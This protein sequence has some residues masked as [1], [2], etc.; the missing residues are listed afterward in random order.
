[1]TSVLIVDDHLLVRQGLKLMLSQEFRDLVFGEAKNNDEAALRL[2]KRS[3]DLVIL[4][5]ALPGKDGFYAL[6]EIRRRH[7]SMRVLVLSMHA[8]P[9]YAMRARQMGAS[10]YVSKNA[11]RAELLRAFKSV[12]AG[13]KYFENLPS[14]GT[15]VKTAPER[16]GL[17]TREHA[18]ML[19]LAAG[20]SPGEIAAELNLSVK[21]ISTYKCR[22]LDKLALH[23]TAGLVRYVIDHRLS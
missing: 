18:V 4:D 19:A 12:L 5:I 14:P 11:G 22:I 2:A 1:M 10:G 9:Q 6:Q 23:S 3:W 8:D 13:Q 16:A 17:S 15:T 20:K 21:T 7:P